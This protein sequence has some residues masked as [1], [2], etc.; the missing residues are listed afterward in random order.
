MKIHCEKCG[1]FVGEIRDGVIRKG[2][3][4]LCREC[5][6]PSEVDNLRNMM[7]MGD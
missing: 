5:A 6:A 1:K 7:G 4:Y 2:T 3:K